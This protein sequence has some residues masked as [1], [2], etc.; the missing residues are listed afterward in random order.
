MYHVGL[1]TKEES[2]LHI[3]NRIKKG[4][5]N[6]NT[7][8][9]EKRFGKRFNDLLTV[10]P[11]CNETTFYDNDNCFVTVAKHKNGELQTIDHDQPL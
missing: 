1:D 9:V 11:Y 10:L 5:H 3:D 6:I 8:A 2:S 4:G 7:D